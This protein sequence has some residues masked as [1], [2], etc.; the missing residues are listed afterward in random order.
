MSVFGVCGRRREDSLLD[1][2]GPAR[3]AGPR[4]RGQIDGNEAPAWSPV[5]TGAGSFGL[6][7]DVPLHRLDNLILHC[8][9]QPL[10]PPIWHPEINETP[11]PQSVPWQSEVTAT[12]RLDTLGVVR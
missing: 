12:R 11:L 10:P 1:P 3:C 9:L 6:G 7:K 5:A 8:L 2:L 4:L